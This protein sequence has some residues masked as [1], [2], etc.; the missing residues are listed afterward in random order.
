MERSKDMSE[1][2]M[3]SDYDV[4]IIGAGLAGLTLAKQLL[5]RDSS[6]DI[7]IVHNRRF[8]YPE[9]IHKVG[10]STIEIGAYYLADTIGCSDHLKRS[11]L[12]KMAMRFIDTRGD[13]H[14]E[15]YKE[16]GLDNYPEHHTFQLDR[17]K[18]ENH[19]R[20]LLDNRVTLSENMRVLDIDKIDDG[21]L[22]SVRDHA[23]V[24]SK[25]KTRWVVDASGRGRVLMKKFSLQK[26]S[27]LN[28]SAVWFRVAGKL[29]INEFLNEEDEI[30]PFR[31]SRERG[32][33]T[34][35]LTGKGYWVWIIPISNETTSVGIVFDNE[36]HN[37]ANMSSYR[38]A[39]EWLGKFEPSFLRYLETKNLPVIDFVMSKNYSY[40]SSKFISNDGWALTGE[41]GGFVDPLYS[42]GTDFIAISNTMITNAITR[43][44]GEWQIDLMNRVLTETYESFVETHR[45]ALLNFG[46]WSYVVVKTSWDTCFYFMFLPVL[47]LNGKIDE[48]DFFDRYMS[49]ITEFHNVHR[50]VTDHLR[51]RAA[52]Q[53]FRD[54]PRFI[55]LA[56]SML[57]Y[58][59]ACMILPDKSDEIVLA[60]LRENMKILNKLADAITIHGDFDKQFHDLPKYLPSPWLLPRSL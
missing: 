40:L 32:H 34:T 25:R 23:G 8:P 52:L 59:H 10:E 41:A 49:D 44:K 38:L 47:Y 53:H 2:L 39:C 11:H 48:L 50:R 15:K 17:G 16:V 13:A 37:L 60:R 46:D 31:F 54:L 6:L 4:L 27:A 57:Q 7:C 9:R 22:V 21:Y 45:G 19:I 20:D 5:D 51:Q 28:R 42:N 55:N 33:S 36:I 24:V 35:H 26:E 1:N 18:I 58:A 56:G 43:P 30:N 3:K 12:R 14:N 29:D